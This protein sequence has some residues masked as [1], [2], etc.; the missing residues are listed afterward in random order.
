MRLFESMF[1]SLQIGWENLFLDIPQQHLLRSIE[2]VRQF[3][4]LHAGEEGLIDRIVAGR[5]WMREGLPDFQFPQ[6]VHI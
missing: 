3:L 4:P 5:P 6:E 1:A 2:L